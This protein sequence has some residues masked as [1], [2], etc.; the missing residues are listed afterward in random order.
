MGLYARYIAPRLADRACMH[1]E[2]T[3]ERAKLIPRAEGIVVEIGIG[4]GLNLAFYDPARVRLVHGIDPAE[5]FLAVGAAR[6][7]HSPVPLEILRAPAE[8]MPLADAIADTVVATY[9]LC[10]VSDPMLALREVRRV[11]KPG[12]N[13]LFLEHVRSHRSRVAPLAGLAQRCVEAGVVRLQSQP[14][15]VG[16]DA[17]CGAADRGAR[18]LRTARHAIAVFRARTRRRTARLIA[19]TTTAAGGR[20][21]SQSHCWLTCAVT[22]RRGRRRP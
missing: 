13:F 20:P 7:A 14:R 17:T 8:A 2:V 5:G 6:F 15:S 4:S 11:L 1:S 21:P 3:T 22:P 18:A 10:S 9:T 19:Q 16:A 12:G